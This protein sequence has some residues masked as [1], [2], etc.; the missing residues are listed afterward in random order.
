M[1]TIHGNG[2]IITIAVIKHLGTNLKRPKILMHAL[3]IKMA[4]MTK[5]T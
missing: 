2:T 1:I 4:Q 3:I 5:K